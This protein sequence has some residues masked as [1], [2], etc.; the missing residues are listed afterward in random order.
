MAILKADK[1]TKMNGVTVN[2]YLLTKHNP[3]KIDMP[4]HKI[5]NL[6]GITVHNT[7]RIIVASNTTPSDDE[8]LRVGTRNT[9]QSFACSRNKRVAL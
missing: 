7:D 6:I 3:N 9:T 8:G 4:T 1:T 5:T 2:K